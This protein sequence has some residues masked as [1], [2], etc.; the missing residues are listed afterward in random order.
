MSRRRTETKTD[1]RTFLRQ[2]SATLGAALLGTRL[3]W[4][5]EATPAGK[6]PN[7]LWITSED[8]SPLLGCYGNRIARTPTLDRLAAEGTAFDHCHAN[9]PV[10]APARFTLITGMYPI[11]CGQAQ[12]MRGSGRPPAGHEPYPLPLRRAGY[13]C[14][15][16]SK[17]DY[18]G[19]ASRDIWDACSREAHW[20]NRPE[21]KPFFSI[22][23]FH[24]THESSIF[25]GRG[26]KP[27]T[28][29]QD[30]HLPDYHPD[31]AVIRTDWA[32]YHDRLAVLDRKVA[33]LLKDLEDDGLADDTIVFYYADHGGVLPRSKRWIYD[34]G[35]HVPLI[36]RFGKNFRNLAPTR[37]G[38]RSQRLV[39]FI[40]FAPTLLSIA[41][42]KPR[43]HM[44]GRAFLGD[45]KAQPP[46]YIHLNRSRMDERYDLIRGLRDQRYLYLRNYLPHL[47]YSQHIAY[48]WR[49]RAMQRWEQLY[50]AGKCNAAQSVFWDP[51]GKPAEELYDCKADPSN[52][53]NLAGSPAHR[54]RLEAMR[55]ANDAFL[56]EIVDTGFHRSG[57]EGWS[58]HGAR[59]RGAYPLEKLLAL[60]SRVS[61]REPRDLPAFQNA[62]ADDDANVRFWGA[63][64]CR[65][66]GKAATPAAAQLQ[67]RL[68]DDGPVTQVIAAEALGVIG[69]AQIALPKLL[70]HL[71]RGKMESGLWAVNALE[72][73]G[74]VAQPALPALRDAAGQGH[75]YIQRVAQHAQHVIADET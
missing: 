66:L 9:S 61:R 71:K 58:Y 48:P 38:Q 23:N 18:N 4:A 7:I 65:A 34:S 68:D 70:Q 10:C 46:S 64:G 28:D 15:N 67:A 12:D 22:F 63:M 11:C 59:A 14:T 72:H 36:V 47:P 39:S 32:R 73:L 35:T 17:T 37:P 51:A 54:D 13:Y 16:N 42:L 50:R 31:D 40:D 69:K 52:V 44:Q 33:R 43:K 75:G 19:G 27:T 62:M 25:P 45:H 3:A 6:R 30:I 41:G 24:T 2:G 49:I 8:N 57:V 74:P 56:L 55:K 21:G 20:R 1:R 26:G 29:P 60:A 5:R 53:R